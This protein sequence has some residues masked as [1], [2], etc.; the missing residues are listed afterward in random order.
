VQPT[1]SPR[2]GVAPRGATE[3]ATVVRIVDGDTIDVRIG[4]VDDTVRYFGVDTPEVGDAL[5]RRATDANRELVGGREV[6][7]ESELT[8]RDRYGRLLRHVWVRDGSELVLVG[9]ELVRRGLATV[10]TY[11]PD[12]QY[13]PVFL[14]AERRAR[15]QERGLW[16]P[17]PTPRP[18]RRPTPKPTHR[19]PPRRSCDPSYPDFCIPPYPP[20][21]DC[22]DVFYE[23]FTVV[24]R[25]P[26]GFDGD[27]DGVGCES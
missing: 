23:D 12:D 1:P 16:A 10:V 26:H 14:R 8:D 25:D 5:S 4:S 19:R 2:L 3:K 22:G 9:A 21:L 7:L 17:E 20:D 6:I 18:T 27:G 24:G 13:E 11:P 15:R